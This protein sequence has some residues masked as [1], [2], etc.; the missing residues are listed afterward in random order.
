MLITRLSTLLHVREVRLSKTKFLQRSR[1]LELELEVGV[2][3]HLPVSEVLGS[4]TERRPRGARSHEKVGQV[5][6][7]DV[8]LLQDAEAQGVCYLVDE[9]S[10]AGECRHVITGEQGG[11]SD[12]YFLRFQRP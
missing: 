2:S 11:P 12:F 1:Q 10:G 5:K 8:L 9:N 3:P 6:S 4:S 7:K